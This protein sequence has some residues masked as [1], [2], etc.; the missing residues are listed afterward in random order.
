MG[1]RADNPIRKR[2]EIWQER[3]IQEAV[4]RI[5]WAALR[6]HSV[7]G[8]ADRLTIAPTAAV[9]DALF[10]TISGTITVGEHAF[11]GH[12]VAVLTGSHDISKTGAERQQAVPDAGNDIVIGPGAWVS[13]R[14]TVIGPCTIGQDAVVAAGAVVTGDVAPGAIVGGVPA[15]PLQ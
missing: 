13:S 15:R 4:A 3:L 7:F 14:A 11:F 8:P 9:N 1:L 5:Q 2:F 12:G 6:E 10:N